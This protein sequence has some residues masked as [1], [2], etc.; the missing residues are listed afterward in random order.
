MFLLPAVCLLCLADVSAAVTGRFTTAFYTFDRA[1][2]D[3][4]TTGA[5]R[6]YQSGRLK[7]TDLGAR[8]ELSF[9]AYGRVSHDFR[10]AAASD[11][12]FRLH[13]AYFRWE[14]SADRFRLTLGRQT[15]FAGVGIGRIDGVRARL[16]AGSRVRVDL[17]GGSLVYGGREGIRSP[18]EAHMVGAHATLDAG[19]STVGASVYRRSREV[20]P[21][22]SSARIFRG[23]GALDIRPGEVEQQMVGFDLNHPF[24]PAVL[25][26][27]WDL[28]TP[29]GLETRRFE[30]HLRA[31][32]AGWTASADFIYRTP[33]LDANSIFA[34]FAASGNR[35]LTLRLN[36]R[37]NRHL[38]L[39]SEMSR[40]VYD[41]A[42][43][44]RLSV[45]ANVLNGYVGYARRTGFGGA[46]DGLTAVLRHRF[47]PVLWA[48]AT[49]GWTRFRTYAGDDVRSRMFANT[50]ALHYRPVS[51]L[52]LTVQ[53]QSLSQDLVNTAADPFSGAG[54]D[55]RLFVSA[56]TWF[57]R[58]GTP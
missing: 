44:Y 38:S 1:L 13:H 46:S 41:A 39:F 40:V 23:L 11:P 33:Y 7:F 51:R 52:N 43:G 57:F 26:L 55:F 3:T 5:L 47:N 4:A 49:S 12:A 32:R 10:D 56:S 53:G 24:G 27:R 36:R 29:G 18:A 22:E 16:G 6:G 20:D 15:V 28:S 25:N 9:Q 54:H 2:Q 34:V 8:P 14:D 42:D 30:A 37:F 58:K 21:Y 17:Y 45:G 35:E 31:N 19:R 48:S 50:L